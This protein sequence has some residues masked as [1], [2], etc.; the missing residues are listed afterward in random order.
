VVFWQNEKK[1]IQEL[2]SF[3][4]PLRSVVEKKMGRFR[5]DISEVI[6]HSVRGL[7]ACGI[8]KDGP[9]SWPFFLFCHI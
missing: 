3:F 9:A 4:F 8:N 5:R 2:G 1:I 6:Y 7:H